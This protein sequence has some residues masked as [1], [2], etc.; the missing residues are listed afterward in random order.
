M[1]GKNTIVQFA[2][3]LREFHPYPLRELRAPLNEEEQGAVDA[4]LDNI[5]T[6]IGVTTLSDDPERS[7]KRWFMRQMCPWQEATDLFPDGPEAKGFTK[8]EDAKQ[9]YRCLEHGA[10]FCVEIWSDVRK[11]AMN[12]RFLFLDDAG[13]PFAGS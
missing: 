9:E 6:V 13:Q 8:I 1:I 11:W 3:D 12:P 2:E 5:V 7:S 10:A 4:C